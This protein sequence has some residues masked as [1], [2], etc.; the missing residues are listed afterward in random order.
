M[1][2]EVRRRSTPNRKETTGPA[3]ASFQNNRHKTCSHDRAWTKYHGILD[4][5][6]FGKLHLGLNNI[7]HHQ[8][9]ASAQIMDRTQLVRY[10]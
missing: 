2:D 4:I 8:R 6:I 5:V 7:R 1:L 10:R 9:E 3:H